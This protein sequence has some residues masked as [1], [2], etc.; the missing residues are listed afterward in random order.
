MEE[1]NVVINIHIPKTGGSSF[2][3]M[4]GMVYRNSYLYLN[5]VNT[6]ESLWNKIKDLDL[7]SISCICGHFPFGVHKYFPNNIRCRYVTFLRDPVD[8]LLSMWNF[9]MSSMRNMDSSYLMDIDN[10]IRW[11]NSGERSFT[12]N[13]MTRIL[14]NMPESFVDP[15]TAEVSNDNFKTARTNLSSFYF[16]GTTE[17]FDLSLRLLS[18]KLNWKKAVPYQNRIY[19]YPN[20]LTKASLLQYDLD[21]ILSK[22]K[23]DVLLWEYRNGFYSNAT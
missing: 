9:N 18:E 16:V 4:L 6:V 8:R 3:S 2:K 11:I 12:D 13:G 15:I 22:H 23:F 5:G 17:T 21:K 10:F 1:H 20:R 7:T 14:S 19:S